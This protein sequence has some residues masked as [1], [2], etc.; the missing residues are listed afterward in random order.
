MTG[1][2]LKPLLYSYLQRDSLNGP[3]LQSCRNH[4]P[5]FISMVHCLDVF[6]AGTSIILHLLCVYSGLV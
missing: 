1:F 2:E 3:Q 5:V 4:R 6:D